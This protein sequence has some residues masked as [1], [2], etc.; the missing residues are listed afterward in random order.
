MHRRYTIHVGTAQGT[1]MAMGREV[2]SLSPHLYARI[3]DF[4]TMLQD[5]IGTPHAP[6]LSYVVQD[7]ESL[8]ELRKWAC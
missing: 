4:L 7:G 1:G 3:N 8:N 5:N 2:E 6:E